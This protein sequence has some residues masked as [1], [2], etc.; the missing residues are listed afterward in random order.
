MAT[1]TEWP[2]L[3]EA[4]RNMLRAT[5]KPYV[6]EN[7]DGAPLQDYVVLCGTD[8]P[9]TP[10]AAASVVRGQFP[11]TRAAAPSASAMPY[12]GQTQVSLRQD[13]RMEGLRQRQ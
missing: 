11:H 1:G 8:V 2:D 13:R 7:V 12:A 10:S 9:E 6:I 4:V 5:G 3:I